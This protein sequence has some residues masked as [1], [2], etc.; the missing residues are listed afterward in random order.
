MA[1]NNCFKQII[2]KYHRKTE[3]HKKYKIT[4]LN[5]SFITYHDISGFSDV[6]ELKARYGG[7]KYGRRRWHRLQRQ[8]V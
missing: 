4:F 5:S 8:R 7:D 3:L 6:I 1:H 2:I